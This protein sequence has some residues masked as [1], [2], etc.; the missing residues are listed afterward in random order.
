MDLIT[1]LQK[2]PKNMDFI[3]VIFDR[4]TK[5]AHFI[6]IQEN[7]SSEKLAD[8]YVKVV[9]GSHGVLFLVVLNQDIKFTSWF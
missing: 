6:A 7:S 2:N 4:L 5:S 8:I 9:I 1:M 3:W